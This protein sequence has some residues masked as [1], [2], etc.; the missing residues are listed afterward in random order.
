M[1]R[2]RFDTSTWSSGAW[3]PDGNAILGPGMGA[4]I[5]N[6]TNNAFTVSFV[7]LVR[8]G[9]LSLSLTAG[10]ASLISAMVPMGAESSRVG[11]YSQWRR[12]PGNFEWNGMVKLP[13]Q[14]TFW[15]VEAGQHDGQRAGYCGRTTVLF[16]NQHQQ[17]L[18][19]NSRRVV[20]RRL[21]IHL[22]L[23]N[24]VLSAGSFS[25]N[26]TGPAGSCWDVYSSSDLQNWT[27]AV[28]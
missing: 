5:I 1:E 26:A 23:T 21:S 11:L 20:G 6:P 19:G 17:N 7:G 2:Q 18:A 16:S 12:Y 14:Q 13:V 22:T 4:F 3:S 27:L 9:S 10:Q 25:F 8:E 28:G 24:G 15:S